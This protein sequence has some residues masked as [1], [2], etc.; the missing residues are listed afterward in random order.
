M[1]GSLRSA[2]CNQEFGRLVVICSPPSAVDFKSIDTARQIQHH[3]SLKGQTVGEDAQFVARP[4]GAKNADAGPRL[5]GFPS[6]PMLSWPPDLKAEARAVPSRRSARTQ[7]S[8]S[9]WAPGPAL[10]RSR[11]AG[12]PA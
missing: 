4:A 11:S 10:L 3:V 6:Q 7:P 1:A 12:L 5:P 8:R 2:G 9:P